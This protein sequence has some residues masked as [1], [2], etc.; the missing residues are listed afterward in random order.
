MKGIF[1]GKTYKD[2]AKANGDS[3]ETIESRV[4]GLFGSD[5]VIGELIES[6]SDHDSYSVGGYILNMNNSACDTVEVRDEDGET[7]E[8]WFLD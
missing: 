2:Y 1:T 8:S 3:D 5:A 4:G 7:I 6:T